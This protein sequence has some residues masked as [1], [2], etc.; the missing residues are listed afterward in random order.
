MKHEQLLRIFD[1]TIDSQQDEFGLGSE[2][3]QALENV[4]AEIYC[5]NS[6]RD[7]ENMHLLPKTLKANLIKQCE[8]ILEIDPYH[9][10]NTG[11]DS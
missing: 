7:V 6:I 4:W 3:G 1:A 5:H 8:H 9:N 11:Q 2:I 10:F